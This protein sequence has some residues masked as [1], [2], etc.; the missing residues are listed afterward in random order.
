MANGLY[1]IPSLSCDV[2]YTAGQSNIAC[3]KIVRT[4]MTWNNAQAYCMGD[5]NA[6]HLVFVRSTEDAAFLKS[7]LTAASNNAPIWIGLRDT[8]GT[9]PNGRGTFT[10][11][12]G[13]APSYVGGTLPLTYTNW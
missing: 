3:Y 8:V 13:S 12:F 7:M 2:G 6:G 10:W 11:N 4:V 5:T 9:A 1:Y